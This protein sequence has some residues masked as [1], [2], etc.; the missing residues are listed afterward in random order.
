M[1]TTM[2]GQPLNP[3]I[4]AAQHGEDIVVG[5]EIVRHSRISRIVHWSVAI[6]FLLAL[7]TGLP[8][9]TPLFGWMAYLFGGLEVCRW[10]HPWAGVFFAAFS[11]WMFFYW[12]GDMRMLPG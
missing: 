6:T 9:W 3:A 11:V 12:L 8:I 7:F 5:N 4:I 1:S 10:L 2:P